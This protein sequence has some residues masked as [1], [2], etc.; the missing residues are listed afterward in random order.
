MRHLAGPESFELQGQRHAQWQI[1]LR[2]NHQL[3][4]PIVDFGST[5]QPVPV[6]SIASTPA[7]VFLSDYLAGRIYTSITDSDDP[8]MSATAAQ[9]R[10]PAD[11]VLG[12]QDRRLYIRN[13]DRPSRG[14]PW[15]DQN[16]VCYT[17]NKIRAAL[18]G[19]PNWRNLHLDHAPRLSQKRPAAEELDGNASSSPKRRRRRQRDAL[20]QLWAKVQRAK[21]VPTAADITLV[22][23]HFT[24]S[25]PEDQAI[26]PATKSLI[27][28]IAFDEAAKQ[29]LQ[30]S[31]FDRC[32]QL[33]RVCYN[34]KHDDGRA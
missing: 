19:N 22:R 24:E 30:V 33:D 17:S 5:A 14:Q 10:W 9:E 3:H 13:K 4:W 27:I 28:V 23:Q 8:P 12:G 18:P 15:D 6:A 29:N 34:L 16:G 11:F 1:S 7:H 26:T 2:P 32:R 21:P 25:R 31:L 20:L